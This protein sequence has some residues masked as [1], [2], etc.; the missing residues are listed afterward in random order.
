MSW[1]LLGLAACSGP[2]STGVWMESSGYDWE[3]F[4][5]RVSHVELGVSDTEAFAS[6][7]GGTS[8]TGV[9]T[10]LAEGCE[11]ATCDEFPFFDNAEIELGWARVTSTTTVFGAASAQLVIDGDGETMTI[12]VPLAERAKG[13]PVAIIR[14]YSFDTFQPLAD[15]D[16]CYQ[17]GN[18]WLPKR[19]GIEL[20]EGVLSD[21]RRSVSVEVSGHFEAGPTFEEERQCLD[22]VIDRARIGLRVDVLVAVTRGDAE[23]VEIEDSAQYAFSGDSANPGEQPEPSLAERPLSTGLDD[24]LV[25]WSRFQF[26]FHEVGED[27]GAYLRTLSLVA[28]VQADVA[29]GHATNYSPITQLSAFDYVFSGTVQAVDVGATIERGQISES[30]EVALDSA[31]APVVLS[32]AL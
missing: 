7:V 14:G 2:E 17:P 15:G 30:I 12:T 19:M 32:W 6:I 26:A 10:E 29:S 18:G 31:G 8:T 16:A 13:D 11:A 24:P 21:D 5:H 23:S 27:R 9:V 25:G 20:G 28:D 22:A 1:V 3:F 4:N